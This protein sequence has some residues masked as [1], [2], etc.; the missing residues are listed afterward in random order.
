MEE[1]MRKSVVVAVLLL[2]SAVC[3][4]AEP[5]PN[6]VVR[7]IVPFGPGGGVDIAARV[8][9]EQLG[10][11]LNRPFV[12]ENR[13]AGG[14]N[15]GISFVAKSAPDGYNLLVTALGLATVPAMFKSPP[16]DVNKDLTPIT[17]L[18]GVPNALVVKPSPQITNL[19]DFIAAAK[20]SPTRFFYGSSGSGG[21]NHLAPELFKRAAGIE[22]D[23]V[24]Y[25]G[26]G[27][28]LTAVM[29]D[30]VQMVIA[31]VIAVLPLV[32]SGKLRALAV[33]TRGDRIES[34]P[35]VPSMKEA[36]LANMDIYF[37]TG[38]LGPA[39]MP[40]DIVET[41]YRESV[42]ALAEPSVK[43]L[44][45]SQAAEIV[46]SRPEEFSAFLRSEVQRWGA[47]IKAAGIQPQ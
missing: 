6:K 44:F 28:T 7:I 17:Q 24:Q 18:I 21:I 27:D 3:Q 43:K 33:T 26:S 13:P 16:F 37:W 30:Q 2:A 12:V 47:V 40:R 32:K 10:K 5:Y 14:G 25:K 41:L 11:Q 34:L 45:V 36:G 19:K 31:P 15:V 38:L 42:K 8:T 20:A 29:G 46:G 35:D 22:L 9:A 1:V 39:G 23:D 4:S